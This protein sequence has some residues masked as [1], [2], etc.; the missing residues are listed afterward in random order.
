MEFSEEAMVILRD[1][2]EYVRENNFEYVTPE[3]ILLIIAAD[4]TFAAAF[5]ECGGDTEVLCENIYEYTEK[6]IDKVSDTD[7][8][9]SSEAKRLL[10]LA[11]HSAYNSG[12]SEVCVRHLVHALW[13]LKNSYAVY[14]IEQQGVE[15]AELL[16]AFISTEEE[17]SPDEN[18]NID[19]ETDSVSCAGESWEL[20]PFHHQY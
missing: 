15:K 7:A 6:Y 13:N 4:S 12:C 18:N 19:D 9:L 5:E 20:N 2:I 3:I 11:G 16:R 10:N 17:T 8:E 1:A 14:F